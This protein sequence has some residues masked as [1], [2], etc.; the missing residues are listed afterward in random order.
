MYN[1]WKFNRLFDLDRQTYGVSLNNFKVLSDFHT[2]SNLN[3]YQTTNQYLKDA[4]AI[5]LKLVCAHLCRFSCV[6]VFIKY[7]MTTSTYKER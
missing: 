6:I 4:E 1:A 5:G 7:Q 3:V 2:F